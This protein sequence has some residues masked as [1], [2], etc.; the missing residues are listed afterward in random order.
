MGLNVKRGRS[1]VMVSDN[2]TKYGMSTSKVVLCGVGSFRVNADSVF[3]C[4]QYGK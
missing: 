3:L 2:N 4:I 1:K